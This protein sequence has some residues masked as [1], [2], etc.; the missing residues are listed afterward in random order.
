MTKAS[1]IKK[2]ERVRNLLKLIYND[3]RGPLNAS[4][5]GEYQ[6]FITYTDDLNRYSYIYLMKHKS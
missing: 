6:Y 5:R 3:V 4:A 1:F 2:G